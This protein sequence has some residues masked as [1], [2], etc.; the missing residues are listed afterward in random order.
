MTAEELLE[1]YAAG[2][3]DFSGAELEGI[4]LK[5]VDLR[6]INLSGANLGNTELVNVDLSG[7]NISGSNMSGASFLGEWTCCSWPKT[8]RCGRNLLHLTA[9]KRRYER[10]DRTV[11]SSIANFGALQK[12]L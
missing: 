11:Q 12:S 1:R 3:S 8:P 2:E 7:S 10:R 4:K 6:D 5:N 9:Q